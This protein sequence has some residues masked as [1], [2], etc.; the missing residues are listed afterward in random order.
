MDYVESVLTRQ[1][2]ALIV[3]FGDHAPVLGTAPD[4]FA[5]S[6]ID[7]GDAA[8]MVRL[9]TTPLLVI[10][11]RNGAGDMGQL[12]L[13]QLAPRMLALLG[14]GHP[15][16]PQAPWIRAPGT[17]GDE[18][19]F[20]NHLLHRKRDGSWQDCSGTGTDCAT[21]RKT[22]EYLVVLRDDLIRG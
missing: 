10:D 19:L 4:P 3:A 2:D 16:L 21:V 22:R 6:G 7:A 18:R 17:I 20:L 9:S 14:E 15:V 5:A 11:G 13:N 12:P 8:G 1:P